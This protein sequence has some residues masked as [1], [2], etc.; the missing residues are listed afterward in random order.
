MEISSVYTMWIYHFD[1]LAASTSG[2]KKNNIVSPA[3][4][5][6]FSLLD[7]MEEFTDKFLS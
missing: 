5:V 2:F 6:D 7:L 4:P 1:M 3:I